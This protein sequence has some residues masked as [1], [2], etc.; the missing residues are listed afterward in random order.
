MNYEAIHEECHQ[1]GLTAGANIK[2]NPMLIGETT[3]V[4]GNEIDYNKPTYV[5]DDGPCGFAWVNI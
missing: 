3:S 1:I 5:L 2:A 4:F